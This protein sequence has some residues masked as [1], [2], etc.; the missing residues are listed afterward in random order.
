MISQTMA[1]STVENY[2]KAILQ[3]EESST[4]RVSVGAIADALEVTPGTVTS[5]MRHLAEERL[6]SYEPRRH[7]SLLSLGKKQARQVVR[8][9]R[10][11]SLLSVR[12]RHPRSRI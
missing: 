9:H 10:L 1:T 4:Q 7:V 2:L 6:I 3:L 5:M 8:R 11:I 12:E